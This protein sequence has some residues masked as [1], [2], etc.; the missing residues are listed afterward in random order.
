[1]LNALQNFIDSYRNEVSR[2][3]YLRKLKLFL[4]L[5]YK[6]DG[7]K[8]VR[9]DEDGTIEKLARLAERF[10]KEAKKDTNDFTLRLMKFLREQK[11]RIERE[12]IKVKPLSK[13]AK[14]SKKVTGRK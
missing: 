13:Y 14:V 4:S 7:N 3:E 2:R 1:M 10:V 12:K 5:F 6:I 9:M 8:I 11:K